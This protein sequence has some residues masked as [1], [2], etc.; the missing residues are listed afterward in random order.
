[1][2]TSTLSLVLL[3]LPGAALA[4]NHASAPPPAVP[5]D[6]VDEAADDV[7]EHDSHHHY[8][9]LAMLVAMSLD[10]L[11]IDPAQLPAV[12]DVR[13]DLYERMEPA[14]AAERA[15]LQALAD[16]VAA[17]LIDSA[18]VEDALSRLASATTGLSERTATDLSQ[19]HSILRPEQRAALV[20][21]VDAHWTLWQRAN[22]EDPSGAEKR[23]G[24]LDK[25]TIELELTPAQVEK[26]RAGI[27]AARE[28]S[29]PM[30]FEEIEARVHAFE[31]FRGESFDPTPLASDAPSVHLASWGAARMARFFETLSPVLDTDQRS[32]LAG[33]LRDH[34]SHTEDQRPS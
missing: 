20:D 13:R 23:R 15:L 33:I 4:C 26:V 34:A 17:D 1:M 2:R 10:T 6:V 8:G 30:A 11:G 12:D 21:K 32:K 14:R 28:G 16:G 5:V 9:G 19:L 29:R 31:A 7:T 27:E 18:R 24:R 25:L 22:G 3:V